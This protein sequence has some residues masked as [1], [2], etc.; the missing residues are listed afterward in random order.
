[1]NPINTKFSIRFRISSPLPGLS[2]ECQARHTSE[3]SEQANKKKPLPHYTKGSAK[4]SLSIE[5]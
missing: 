1:M 5:S 4:E 2:N 3:Y